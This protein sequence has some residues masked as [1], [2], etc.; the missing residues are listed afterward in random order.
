MKTFSHKNGFTLPELVVYC[1]ILT[2]LILVV[3]MGVTGVMK[4]YGMV[5]AHQE[6]SRSASGA[7]E[8]I[9]RD[10]RSAET[11]DVINS[12]LGVSPGVLVLTIPVTEVT[13]KTVR[14]YL[15]NGRVYVEEDGVLIGALTT[16]AA[17]ISVLSFTQIQTAESQG[18]RVQMTVDAS[19]GKGTL[20]DSFTTTAVLRGS[21]AI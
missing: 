14:F 11:I 4:S 13:N 12:T 21:Y 20:T 6:I 5:R 9:V 7:L 10:I 19:H 18:V 16:E 8:R 15:Q 17:V 3:M 2:L 1:A